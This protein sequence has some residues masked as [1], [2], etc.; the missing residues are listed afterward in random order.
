MSNLYQKRDDSDRRENRMEEIDFE[1]QEHQKRLLDLKRQQEE[2]ERRKK[3]LEA[4]TK[5]QEELFQGQKHIQEKLTRA[6]TVLERAEYETR[7][8]VEEIE[9][10]RTN[11]RDHLEN[12]EKISPQDWEGDNI[13][14]ELTKALSL[15][16]HAQA[17]Y[18]QSRA[19]L[20]ALS[21]RDIDEDGE[22]T[23][24]ESTRTEE[25]S[26]F[27]ELVKRGLAFTLPLN[28]LLLILIVILVTANK[29]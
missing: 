25:E 6:L 16:D 9:V 10:I 26:G 15:I 28:I 11:F 3:E 19:R 18:N 4:L 21:G 29:P 14:N 8:Q 5:R 13:D 22:A 20:D 24:S 12:V 1:L 17:V 2:V 27:F 7:K 23:S